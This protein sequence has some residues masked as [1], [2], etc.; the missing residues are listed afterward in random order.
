GE[1]AVVLARAAGRRARGRGR[2]LRRAAPRARDAPAHRGRGAAW[3]Q[4]RPRA[5]EPARLAPRGRA[6]PR[7]HRHRLLRHARGR[8][9]PGHRRLRR[10]ARRARGPPDRRDAAP[11]NGENRM[12]VALL[13]VLLTL[14][15]LA[16]ASASERPDAQAEDRLVSLSVSTDPFGVFL[17]QMEHQGALPLGVLST[18]PGEDASARSF[19]PP[20]LTYRDFHASCDL[21]G[22][23]VGDLI[24]NDLELSRPP[25]VSGAPSK[26]V[27]V[28]G[29]TGQPIWKRDNLYFL[30]LNVAPDVSYV[31][32][33]EPSPDPARNVLP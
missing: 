3:L 31:R 32:V 11:L 21:N 22:D 9:G 29:A 1:R 13:L 28:D 10:S 6:H 19:R 2:G 15:P 16:G 8:A 24:S 27:A 23:G 25:R 20:E 14:L 18:P 7:R 4:A 26:I 5:R 17:A 30:A 12:R 33:G